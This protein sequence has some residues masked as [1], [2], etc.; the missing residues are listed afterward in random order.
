MFAGDVR[1]LARFGCDLQTLLIVARVLT[2]VL[3]AILLEVVKVMAVVEAQLTHFFARHLFKC[4][5]KE[6]VCFG[7]NLLLQQYVA[8]SVCIVGRCNGKARTLARVPLQGC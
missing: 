1:H 7:W 3:E 5:M 2:S 8:K 4:K 6:K